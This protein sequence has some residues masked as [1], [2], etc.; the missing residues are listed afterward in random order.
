MHQQN[1]H[2]SLQSITNSGQYS[3]QI[4][5][6]PNH[7]AV[8]AHHHTAHNLQAQQS[9]LTQLTHYHQASNHQQ[10]LQAAMAA[11]VNHQQPQHN[12]YTMEELSKNG[13]HLMANPFYYQNPLI[14]TNFKDSAHFHSASTHPFSINSIIEHNTGNSAADSVSAALNAVVANQQGSSGN[15]TPSFAS[16]P[17]AS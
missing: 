9:H 6:L 7:H 10:Q 4:N 13:N 14:G 8:A 16:K 17:S 11:A 5:S 3:H 2:P 15:S 12:E 1:L